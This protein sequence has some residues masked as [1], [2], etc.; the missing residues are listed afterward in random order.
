MKSSAMAT[1]ALLFYG[2]FVPVFLFDRALFRFIFRFIKKCQ[3]GL[4]K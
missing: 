1:V 2:L 4:N 3:G